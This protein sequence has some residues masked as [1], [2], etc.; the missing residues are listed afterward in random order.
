MSKSDENDI[1]SSSPVFTVEMES[2]QDVKCEDVDLLSLSYKL[3]HQFSVDAVG[4]CLGLQESQVQDALK[5]VTEHHPDHNKVHLLLIKW[6][7]VNGDNATWGTL[8][9]QTQSNPEIAGIIKG[10]K[11]TLPRKLRCYFQ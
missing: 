9:D 6:R 1:G 4:Q 7:E 3:A 2:L 8:I 11:E 10:V 5:R